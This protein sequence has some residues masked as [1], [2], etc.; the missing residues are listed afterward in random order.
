MTRIHH[1]RLAAPAALFLGLSMRVVAASSNE[2]AAP[3]TPSASTSSSTTQ[4]QSPAGARFTP[5]AQQMLEAAKLR[6]AQQRQQQE[7]VQQQLSERARAEQ[8]EKARQLAGRINE[9]KLKRRELQERNA[10]HQLQLAREQRL[11]E[12][13]NQ[14]LSRYQRGSYQEAVQILQQMTVLAPDHPLV[15]AG[16]RLIARAELKHFEERLRAS[17]ESPK[18]EGAIVPELE[19][20]LLQKRI[21]LET[22]LKYAKV[23]LQERRYA[24]A[25][26]LLTAVLV[27]DPAHREAHEL[28]ER[29]QWAELTEERN[30]LKSE[31]RRDEQVM[32]NEV[33]KAQLLPEQQK[34]R[35]LPDALSSGAAGGPSPAMAAKL[36][37]PISFEFSAVALSDVLQFVADAANVSIIPSPQLDLKTTLVSMKVTQLPLEQA[38]KYLAKSLSLAYRVESDAILVST[39][40]ELSSEPMQTRVFFLKSG[41][42][43]FGLETAALQPNPALAMDSITT[44][45]QDSVPSPADSKFIVDQRTGSLVVTNTAEN[46]AL[47]ERLLSQLDV[48][49]IQVLIEARFIELTMTDLSQ[50]GLESVLTGNASL[51]KTGGANDTEGAGQQLASGAGFKF[52]ALARESEGVNLT[53]QGVLTGTQFEAAL[54]LLEESKKTKTLSAPRVTTLNNQT[55]TIRV[56]DEFN[57]PTRYEVSLIQFDI[58]GDG[59]FDDAGETEFANVPQDLQKRDVGILL[60]VTPSVGRD[61]KTVTLVLAPEVSS[62]SQFRDLGGGVTVPE[63]TSS[64]LTTSILIEDGQTVM[65]GGLMKDSI[66]ETVTKVPVLGDLPLVGNLFR[67][68]EAS[69]TRKNLLIFIT[70]RVLAPRG[71]TT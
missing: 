55:A 10:Q 71:Q 20:L 19:H 30:R 46:L 54:H 4:P 39:P 43:P 11:K 27:Q 25:Q 59:D 5:L 51:M 33:L 56:V 3:E 7:Q 65:L 18:T 31:T 57:Y 13:Y 15:K 26:K 23:A 41:L 6:L 52:P 68:K 58:N 62:F 12:L 67:Q 40:Q 44:L 28:M 1:W 16:E 17:V 14:A 69:S 34:R 22:G 53:L 36:R 21:E 66:S 35:L 60:N 37:Q 63:F 32:L 38:I 42:S 47:I 45:I 29:A 9:G 64:Q 8:I 24:T 49:P 2:A 70:A 50:L 48:T 61:L